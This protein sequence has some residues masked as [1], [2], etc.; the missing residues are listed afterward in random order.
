ME[1]NGFVKNAINIPRIIDLFLSNLKYLNPMTKFRIKREKVAT[2][3][4]KTP[5]CSKNIKLS[6]SKP[7][8]KTR[9]TPKINLFP[10]VLYF[11]NFSITNKTTKSIIKFV[12][13][14]PTGLGPITTGS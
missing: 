7:H 6:D 8:K 14:I 4:E 3:R 10:L 12:T 5:N 13:R 2:T 11:N 1:N 9:I